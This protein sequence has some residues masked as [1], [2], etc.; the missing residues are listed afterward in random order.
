MRA[1]TFVCILLFTSCARGKVTQVAAQTQPPPLDAHHGPF[2]FHT[3]HTF[4]LPPP[5][6]PFNA[7][8]VI[9]SLKRSTLLCHPSHLGALMADHAPKDWRPVLPRISLPCLNLY[10]DDSGCFP[11]AGCEAVTELIGSNC[12]SEI[13]QG[14]NHWCVPHAHRSLSPSLACLYLPAP[15]LSSS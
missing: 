7:A 12:R 6:P 2:A 4:I 8:G 1:R 10:G 5:S 14:C 13:F 9:S 3:P 15:S 11:A